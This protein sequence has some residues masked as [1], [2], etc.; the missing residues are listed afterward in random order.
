MP[1]G[2]LLLKTMKVELMQEELELPEGVSVTFEGLNVIV[3]GPKGEVMRKLFS[4]QVEMKAESNRVL[5][6]AKKATKR[7]KRMIGTF[8]AHIRN[9][10]KGVTEGHFYRLKICSGHFPMNISVKGNE[11]IVKN[12]MGEKVPRVLKLREGVDI[13][14]EGTEVRIESPNKELAGQTA[15]SIEQLCRRV[16]FDSRIFQ[17]GIFIV[18]KDGKIIK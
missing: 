3:K 8:R 14:V 2:L 7:E 5:F 18:E 10:V 12:F 1:I 11:F 15:A 4:K 13:K 17:D 9:I 6:I 16:G